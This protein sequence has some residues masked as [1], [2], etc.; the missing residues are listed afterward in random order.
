MTVKAVKKKDVPALGRRFYE[1][2]RA[3]MEA[4]QWGRMVVI[5]VTTGDYE[6]ADD[7]LTATTRLFERNPEAMTW[8]ELVGHSAAYRMG[9]NSLSF[10]V[11]A[12]PSGD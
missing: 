11:E 8:G 5:D 10:T 12:Q 6:V 7:D 4:K 2:I 3:D 9:G 1:Q